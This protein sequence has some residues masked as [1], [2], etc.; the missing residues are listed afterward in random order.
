M[1]RFSVSGIT[2]LAV[3]FDYVVR[4]DSEEDAKNLVMRMLDKRVWPEHATVNEHCI[5]CVQPVENET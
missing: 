4:A 1:Q 5:D 2:F 3:G